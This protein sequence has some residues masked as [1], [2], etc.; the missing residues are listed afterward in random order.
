[1][2][3]QIMNI[4]TRLNGVVFALVLA[5]SAAAVFVSP[6]IS[7]MVADRMIGAPKLLALCHFL[8]ALVAVSLYLQKE[9]APF[10]AL[11][12]LYMLLLAPTISL[13]NAITF[14]HL[15]D[16]R[17]N[18]GGI[19]QWGTVGWIAVGWVFGYLWLR[20]GSGDFHASSTEWHVVAATSGVM[21]RKTG[22]GGEY[23]G[24]AGGGLGELGSVQLT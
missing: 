9:F 12:L 8:G 7:A 14:H 22:G 23:R 18:F 5:M 11:F 24:G 3:L 20:G 6:F 19:R 4:R 1:M 15:P 21:P 17:R 16:A 13:T 2:S 10:I